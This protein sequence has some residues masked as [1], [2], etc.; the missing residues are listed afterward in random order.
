[1]AAA[2]VATLSGCGPSEADSR[3]A[4]GARTD[5]RPVV[6]CTV[7]M[8]ADLVERVAGEAF[9]VRT[10]LGRGVDP[11]LYT[12]TTSDIIDCKEAAAVFY[13]GLRL[14]GA[15]ADDL[16][17]LSKRQAHVVAVGDA[18][19]PERLIRLGEAAGEDDAHPGEFDPH[20]WM[21]VS[22][23]AETLPSIVQTLSALEPSR[24]DEFAANGESLR[25]T[26]DRL[27]RYVLDAVETVPAERRILISSHDAFA[28][29]GRAYGVR[30]QGVQG[31]STESEAGV[32]DI[33]NL[34]KT[35]RETGLGTVFTET[36]T[37]NKQIDA[38]VEAA[39]SEGLEVK[40][41]GDLYSDST[42]PEGTWPGTY[43]GMVDHNTTM[44][45]TNLGG[46]V[47]DGGFRGLMDNGD[48]ATVEAGSS[49]AGS[50]E[51]GGL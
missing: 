44:L 28:Y 29:F 25:R 50:A 6:V 24:A 3:G 27:H 37:S 8:L 41:T 46:T 49:E 21:D 38:L 32:R 39:R 31:V 23:W 14:E 1:M 35:L 22:L 19:P 17:G 4:A 7:P 45:V 16:S 13:V 33:E 48:A 30:V 34:V 10:L 11:H 18:L 40:A 12:P 5:A 42:G 51:A 2:L 9:D 15:L 26:L 43:L 20:V 36:S 47:P